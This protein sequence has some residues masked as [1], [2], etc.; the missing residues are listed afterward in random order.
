[1]FSRR[2]DRHQDCPSEVSLTISTQ[3]F[4]R[5]AAM[6]ISTV[7]LL[8]AVRK[9]SHALLLLFTAFFLAL[10]LNGPV[11]WLGAHLPGRGRGSRK[12]ATAVSFLIVVILLGGFIASTVPPVIRQTESFINAAPHLI[13]DFRS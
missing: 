6:I 2:P 13:R 7:H 3:S 11:S 12:L 5:L 9:A 8:L 1:M 10:A 4:F